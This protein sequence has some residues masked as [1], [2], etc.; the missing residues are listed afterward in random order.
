MKKLITLLLLVV[1]SISI[2]AQK[3]TYDFSVGNL[4][5][6]ITAEREVE[7]VRNEGCVFYTQVGTE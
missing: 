3:Y 2:K 5:F 4:C 7:L 1:F 6:D